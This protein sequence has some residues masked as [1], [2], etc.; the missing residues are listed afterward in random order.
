MVSYGDKSTNI[1][2]LGFLYARG[3]PHLCTDSKAASVE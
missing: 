1:R 2:A 3:G